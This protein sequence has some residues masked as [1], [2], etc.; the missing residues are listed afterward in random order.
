M[1]ENKSNYLSKKIR[2]ISNTSSFPVL[3]HYVLY[4]GLLEFVRPQLLS[5]MR[6]S[7]IITTE[8]FD[9]FLQYFIIYLIIFPVTMLVFYLTNGRKNRIYLKQCIL[10]PERSTAWITK[11]LIIAF[12]VIMT[13]ST[14]SLVPLKI[15]KQITGLNFV[16]SDD[17]LFGLSPVATVPN[18]VVNIVPSIIFAP[19]FEELLF[20]GM[21]FKNNQKLGELFAVV[22]SGILFGI[23]HQQFSHAIFAS[24][25]GM[26]CCYLYLKTK[27]I[28]PS[29]ILHFIINVRALFIKSISSDID[30][31]SIKSNFFEGIMDNLFPILLF[32]CVCLVFGIITII[33]LVLFIMEISHH[34]E[35]C[36]F[37]EGEFEL[38]TVKK[39]LVYFS[40]PITIITYLCY[41]YSMITRLF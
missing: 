23:W 30:F 32:L 1:S 18:F 40:A 8:N 2:T 26:F 11:W 14:V 24:T 37:S 38:S 4:V 27:S 31:N 7:G 10:K 12:S 25:V 20:R 33:G 35:S 41:L 39:T 28:F 9:L 6:K 22:T 17:L 34:K 13:V 15:L 29:M 19:I 3:V 16:D 21:I 36:R 5:L